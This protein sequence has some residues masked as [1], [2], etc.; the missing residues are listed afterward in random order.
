MSSSRFP[1]FYRLDLEAR[2]AIAADM[3]G[4]STLALQSVVESGG[5]SLAVAD[6]T[7]EN[8]IGVY[9]LPLALGLNVHM[10]GKDYVVP[11]AV[12]EPSVVAAASNAARWIR[13]GGGFIAESDPS[14]TI[15]QVQFDLVTDPQSAAQKLE[16]NK[17]ALLAKAAT[18]MPTIV[19][20]GGGPR[21]LEYR[22]LGD[23]YFVVHLLLDTCDAMGA[24]IANTVAEGLSA[25]LHTLVQ[26]RLGLRILSN[27]ADQ[28]CVRVKSVVPAAMLVCGQTPGATVRDAIV[29]ASIFAEKDP[30]R[31]ATH[32]KGTMNGIDPVVIATGNDWR[33][34]EA[35][36]HAFAART[37]QYKPLCTWR[38]DADGNLVGTMEVPMALGIVGGTLRLHQGA[39]LGLAIS[40]ITSAQE[41]A[42]VAVCVGMAS[43]LAA[44]R[45][46][47]TVGIQQG[48]MALHARSVAL[49]AGAKA[50]LVEVV[51]KE[52]SNTGNV[53]IEAAKKI[54]ARLEAA[55]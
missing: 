48:H 26:G 42:M 11:M 51:A 52:L 46:L 45:A 28:R 13:E 20:R 53:T 41:L 34:V 49:A 2:Q 55:A 1:G 9:S 39:Q 47:A 25:D 8:V 43:N 36:A 15:A 23:G 27:L 6:K 40:Q 3:A 37:G 30:Y 19:S 5:L 16:N 50:E 21:G 35:G 17:E 38:A 10:N 24:N 12:E 4:V 54:V 14:I 7:V 29:R 33:A 22:D 18:L 32:N 31:A 44:L